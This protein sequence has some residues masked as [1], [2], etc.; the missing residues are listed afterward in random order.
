VLCSFSLPAVPEEYITFRGVVASSQIS[1][2]LMRLLLFPDVI[3]VL[4]SITP[5]VADVSTPLT[6]QYCTVLL[7]ASAINLM[8]EPEVLVLEIVNEL[9]EPVPSCLPSKIIP[10]F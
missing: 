4:K 7:Q 6:I 1:Q 9:V 2:K 10:L 5:F 3:A 8:V